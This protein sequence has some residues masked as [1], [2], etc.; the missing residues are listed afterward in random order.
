MGILD[1]SGLVHSKDS[2]EASNPKSK[3]V[4][5][6][7]GVYLYGGNS[8]EQLSRYEVSNALFRAVGIAIAS[9]DKED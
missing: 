2:P 3:I 9:M 5:H 6:G 4:K 8:E 1:E 7:F